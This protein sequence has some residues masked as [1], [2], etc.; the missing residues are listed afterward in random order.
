MPKGRKRGY[1]VN[2]MALEIWGVLKPALES[3]WGLFTK[4]WEIAGFLINKLNELWSL[5]MDTTA[6][7]VFMGILNA[8]VE[9]IKVVIQII[10]GLISVVKN[11]FD[12]FGKVLGL[13]EKVS[14]N[15]PRNYVTV[16]DSGG[17]NGMASGGMT[18]NN[19]F[20]INGTE[21]LSNSR[22]IEVA[23]IITDRVN[24]NLG[25]MV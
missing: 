15:M 4:V 17:F 2:K 16:M 8:I 9:T 22:L 10:G 11:L 14:T 13:E 25:R 3:M 24:E 18:V 12:W 5:F 7:K 1:K 19:S 20:V 21:Q 23:D 6:G